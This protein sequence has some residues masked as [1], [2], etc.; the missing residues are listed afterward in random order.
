VELRTQPHRRGARKKP[1]QCINRKRVCF[2]STD[3]TRRACATRPRR[4]RSWTFTPQRMYLGLCCGC[5]CGCGC[6]LSHS[7]DCRGA[8][9]RLK[10]RR[11]AS[12]ITSARFGKAPTVRRRDAASLLNGRVRSWRLDVHFV[13]DE[14]LDASCVDVCVVCANPR[15]GVVQRRR[16]AGVECQH[17]NVRA[18][19]VCVAPSRQAV[20]AANVP[21]VQHGRPFVNVQRP[22]SPA[23]PP[24]AACCGI[25]RRCI[26]IGL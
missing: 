21:N 15:R 16:A 9:E 4:R 5:G 23:P 7:P 2:I 3:D 1:R 11:N 18:L 26:A 13:G 10:R 24:A 8:H 6:G 17:K 14:R 22:A 12:T 19:K 25:L 20:R